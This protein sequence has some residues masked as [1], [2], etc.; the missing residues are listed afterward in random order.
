MTDPVE[1]PQMAA[2]FAAARQDAQTDLSAPVMARLMADAQAVQ[3]RFAT[4][5][6]LR[7]GVSWRRIWA[8]IGGW[9]A[10]GALATATV[11]GVWI[12]GAQPQIFDDALNRLPWSEGLIL[13]VAFPD[14]D[15]LT[16]FEEI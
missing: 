11:A 7:S 15:T 5:P 16:L 13:D 6:A 1:T 12:G 14:Y 4:P 8:D 2:L 10:L 3:V 9:P